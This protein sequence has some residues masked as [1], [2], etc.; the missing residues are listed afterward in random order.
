MVE[1][2]IHYYQRWDSYLTVS[3]P[4]LLNNPKSKVRAPPHCGSSSIDSSSGTGII[5]KIV[6]TL[7]L[8]FDP[9]EG[10]SLHF[11]CNLH[12]VMISLFELHFISFNCLAF[13]LFIHSMNEFMRS[14][15]YHAVLCIL[16]CLDRTVSII[17]SLTVGLPT[18]RGIAWPVF[19]FRMFASLFTS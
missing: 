11:L 15:R 16:H 5:K 6:N 13:L 9:L 7:H 18:C 19:F 10:S 14:R 1:C 2:H 17:V 3:R 8:C 4:Q 12:M